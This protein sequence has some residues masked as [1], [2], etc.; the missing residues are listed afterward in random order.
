MQKF[1]DR[2]VGAISGVRAALGRCG[3][4]SSVDRGQFF[5]LGARLSLFGALSRR[6]LIRGLRL[7][8][9]ERQ[10]SNQGSKV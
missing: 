7:G 9:P 5:T 8:A 2:G 1:L 10:E 6:G 3:N 4:W